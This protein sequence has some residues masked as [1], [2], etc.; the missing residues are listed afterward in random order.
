M[1]DEGCALC[2]GETEKQEIDD[3]REAKIRE[4]NPDLDGDDVHARVCT[5]CGHVSYRRS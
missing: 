5:E 1:T 2:G 4:H 3:D